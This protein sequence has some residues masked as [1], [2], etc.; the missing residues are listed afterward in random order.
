MAIVTLAD[1]ASSPADLCVVG[2]G[3]HVGLPLALVFASKGR[4]V[5]IHDLATETL[6]E[7][8]QG[9]VP[10]EERGAEELLR[11]ALAAGRLTLTSDPACLSDAP[12]IVVTIG[13][14]VDEHLS[15]DLMVMSRWLDSA[16]PRLHD[17][18]LLVLRST[19]YPGTTAW[20]AKQLTLAGK[21]IDVAYCPERVVQ[22]RAVEE[23]QSLPQLVSGATPQARQRAAALF[24]QIAPEVVPL[25]PLEAEFAKLFTNAY[26]YIQFA[27]A[28][29]FF[30]IANTAGV[31]YA[32]ILRA[33]K[34]NYSRAR[35]IP[36][37]GLT[38]GPCLLKD[39]MQLAAYSENQFSLGSAAMMVNEGLALYIAAEIKR[40]HP[41][42]EMTVGLLGMAFKAD[43]DDIRSSLSYKLRKALSLHAGEV[44]GTDP[45]V[46]VDPTLRPLEEVLERSDLLVLC[47]PHTAYRALDTRGKPVVDIWN[48][49]GNGSTI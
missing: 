19:V 21:Q 2:G 44:L 43:N 8:R 1:N 48:F 33:L 31:D 47:V 37:A 5:I 11:D 38:A 36:G 9:R 32:N 46:R 10:F 49:F 22:G 24:E 12:A 3:G 15:P 30:M 40:K 29:Q 16:L 34:Q 6:D 14:P 7:I 25:E 23:V 41:L 20:L 27:A 26:R 18:Q 17:G 13:T 39:T 42:A 45:L 35:D 28:N 4:Q